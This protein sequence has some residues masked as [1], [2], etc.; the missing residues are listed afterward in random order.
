VCFGGF[1]LCGV[2]EKEALAVRL[3]QPFALF[4]S[5]RKPMTRILKGQTNSEDLSRVTAWQRIVPSVVFVEKG[6][7]I[8]CRIDISAFICD[9]IF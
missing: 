5:F 9:I 3:S 2:E 7:C 4:T 8:S 1:R 6:F